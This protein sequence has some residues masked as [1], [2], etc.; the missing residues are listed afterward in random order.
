MVLGVVAIFFCFNELQ[1]INIFWFKL[2]NHLISFSTG[3]FHRV[4]YSKPAFSFS[5]ALG[6]KWWQ[7]LIMVLPKFLGLAPKR[8]QL[9]P[10]HPSPAASGATFNRRAALSLSLSLTVLPFRPR[11]TA[12]SIEGLV[13]GAPPTLPAERQGANAREAWRLYRCWFSSEVR[14]KW[15]MWGPGAPEWFW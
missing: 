4:T 8:H 14:Q 12:S 6:G 10:N 3:F 1:L 11:S 5:S 15:G 2:F 13:F 7:G 9:C